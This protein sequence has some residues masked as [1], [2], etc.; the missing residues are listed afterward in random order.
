[1]CT[2][3]MVAQDWRDRLTPQYPDWFIQPPVIT[4]EEFDELKRELQAVKKLLAAAKIYDAETGQPDCED[5]EKTKVFRRL[6]E[7]A[8]VDL[9][10]VF[11]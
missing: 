7:L 3:S 11:S 9:S 5:D 6:A 4:R 10:K 2:V 8:G 1:M